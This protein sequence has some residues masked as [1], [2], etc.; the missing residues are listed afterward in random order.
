[1]AVFEEDRLRTLAGAAREWRGSRYLPLYAAG[2]I[3]GVGI[4]VGLTFMND[5]SPQAA[6][7]VP[8]AAVQA[9]EFPAAG[10]MPFGWERGP[11]ELP[12][13]VEVFIPLPGAD[14]PAAEEP[15]LPVAP[16]TVDAPAAAA[17]AQPPAASA[18]PQSQP[19]EAPAPAA[20]HAPE[21][22]S[23]FY[24]PS[25][26]GGNSAAES[27]LLAGMNAERAA[28]GL[29]P[30]VLDSGLTN[31]ARIR[32]QQLIDQGYFGHIDPHGYKMYAELLRHF[33]YGF[34]AAGENLA[35]NNYGMDQSPEVA[36]EGLMNSA[37]HRANILAGDFWRVGVGMVTAADGRH[38]YTVIFLA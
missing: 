3:A 25:S 6:P 9:P 11:L 15:E 4:G 27:R 16:A 26:V 19:I 20:P 37:T 24:I 32:S 8:Q 5:G 18:P 35:M 29:S 30:F 13:E 1:M 12:D 36:L 31:I 22:V 38:F 34:A 10:S 7:V 17:P 2:I 23:N 14:Q 21:P 28:H 33:G